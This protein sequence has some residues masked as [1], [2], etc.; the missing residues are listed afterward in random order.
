MAHRDAHDDVA[1]GCGLLLVILLSVAIHAAL[2][3]YDL[4][5]FEALL[6]ADRAEGRLHAIRMLD[7]RLAHGESFGRILIDLGHAG[8]FV[9]HY[10]PYAIAGIPGILVMQIMLQLVAV[11]LL[12]RLTVTLLGSQRMAT[13]AAVAY[14]LL[15][16]TLH[17][18]H[19]IA[20]E[21]IFNPL[22]I[23]A[24][25]L[26]VRFLR[27]GG[28]L[29]PLAGAGVLT[30]V[31]SLIRPLNLLLPVLVA[32]ALFCA[33]GRRALVP[34]TVYL[35]IASA[36][37]LGWMAFQYT[38]SGEL[39][40]MGSHGLGRNM[41]GRIDRMSQIAGFQIA[42]ELIERQRMDVVTF[43]GYVAQHPDTFLRTFGSDLLNGVLNSGLNSFAGRYLQ[44]YEIP[45]GT[46]YSM[47]VRDE[48]GWLGLIKMVMTTSPGLAI[49]NLLGGAAWLLFL[50]ITALGAALLWRSEAVGREERILIFTVPAY[51]ILAGQAAYGLRWAY[52]TPGEFLLA[53]MFAAG[54]V[55]LIEWF[56]SRSN[57]F[58][59][60]T[61]PR[62]R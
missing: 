7:Q 46:A 48:S 12:F 30:S 58:R 1:I 40:A 3:I 5:H 61:G 17:H 29:A 21:A 34:G 38:Q 60:P 23:G 57:S 13:V 18:T 31:A 11:Y 53:I 56:A 8:D 19:T 2:L 42:P 9:F 6:T 59:L 32:I 51:F 20:S 55:W 26:L 14:I 4:S 52:R 41:Y 22:I 43:A 50:M 49:T 36:L 15:P 62:D 47:Q 33:R 54:L 39:T 45:G 28:G 27:S 44:L 16:G 37:P 35:V 10:L 25:Y 24:V